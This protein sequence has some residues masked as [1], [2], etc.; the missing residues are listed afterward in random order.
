MGDAVQSDADHSDKVQWRG[1][2]TSRECETRVVLRMMQK[3]G[4][5]RPTLASRIA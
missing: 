1:L 3:T 5:F 4:H 2:K